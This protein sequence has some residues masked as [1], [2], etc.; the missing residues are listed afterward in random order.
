MRAFKRRLRPWSLAQ[1]RLW[2]EPIGALDTRS[3]VHS[4]SRQ[5]VASVD[6][7]DVERFGEQGSDGGADHRLRGRRD[8]RR[9]AAA[10]ALSGQEVVGHRPRPAARRDP[11]RRLAAAHARPGGARALSLRRRSG[12]IAFRPRRH[13]L[14]TM[15]SQDTAAA[16]DRLRQ[17][18]VAGAAAL[19]RAERRRQRA[20]GAAAV[21]ECPRRHG[22]DARDLHDARRGHRLRR[23]P[24]RHFRDRPLPGR[25]RRRRRRGTG[26][27]ARGREHRRLSRRRM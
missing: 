17:A 3:V 19:L 13:V 25:Q 7:P 23:P 9:R 5:I 24:P 26:G 16:L 15:K 4:E 6:P 14:L 18:G 20:D 11:L 12:E 8:R 2:G 1:P 10:L 27:G 21:P 22:D